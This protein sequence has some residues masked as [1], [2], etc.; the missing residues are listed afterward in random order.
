MQRVEAE[1]TNVSICI[2]TGV[3]QALARADLSKHVHPK[4]LT[5]SSRD[6]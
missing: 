1:D 4:R 3:L 2:Y 5:G 6:G